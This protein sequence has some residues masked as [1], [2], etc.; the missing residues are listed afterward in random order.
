[1]VCCQNALG[2]ARLGQEV[3][4]F[5]VGHLERVYEPVLEGDWPVNADRIGTLA[6]WDLVPTDY[7]VAL[8]AVMPLL[9]GQGP[10]LVRCEVPILAAEVRQR[11][12]RWAGAV[13]AR[14]ALWVEPM[15]GNCQ[16]VLESIVKCLEHEADLL[17]VASRPAARLLPERR[18]W[19]GEP[20]GIRPGGLRRLRRT[21]LDHGFIVRDEYGL[22]TPVAVVL[23]L[24]AGLATRLGRP[25]LG[26]R[27]IF[28]ARLR[29]ASAG[30]VASLSTVTL[31]VARRPS[32]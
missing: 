27:L 9:T 18:G 26:D 16:A 10:P 19:L 32:S 23:N 11:L 7:R 29:Y 25:D 4:S 30:P 31:L 20:L 3:T 21:L 2:L 22:H 28:A 5:T 17:V 14:A 13:P 15:R 6:R 1:M 8:D 12:P 24:L